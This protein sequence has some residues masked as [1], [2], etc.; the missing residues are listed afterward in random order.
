[1]SNAPAR[2]DIQWVKSTYSGGDGGQC[3]EWS[4]EHAARHG[5]VPVRDSKR[6]Q[7]PTLML[8][9]EAFSGLVTLA[10]GDA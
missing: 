7:G 6:P 5:V 3:L 4:P 1:M 9:P 2:T 10:R 8:T